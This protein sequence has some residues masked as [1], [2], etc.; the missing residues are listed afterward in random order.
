[1]VST[2]SDTSV[3]NL[4][5][6]K[7]DSAS[8]AT[9]GTLVCFSTLFVGALASNSIVRLSAATS[10]SCAWSPVTHASQRWLKGSILEGAWC[11]GVGV[12]A[13]CSSR[14]HWVPV[15]WLTARGAWG[16]GPT[17]FYATHLA[18]AGYRHFVSSDQPNQPNQPTRQAPCSRL[19]MRVTLR[20][21]Q[22][23]RK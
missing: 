6:L 7:S 23:W 14:G 15:P 1:M 18:L 22:S 8:S 9:S 2:P 4:L 12:K 5:G 21:R 13:G 16:R 3:A 17:A 20:K 11:A 19:E 10:L